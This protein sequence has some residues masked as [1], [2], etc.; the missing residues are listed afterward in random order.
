MEPHE[1]WQIKPLLMKNER[2]GI[3]EVCAE[4]E[5][6]MFGVYQRV[7]GFWQWEHDLPTRREAQQFIE[8]RLP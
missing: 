2:N 1:K 7:D 4:H 8:S 5:A 6:Q 3:V